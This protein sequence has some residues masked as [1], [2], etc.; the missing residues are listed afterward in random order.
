M[1]D[2][3]FFIEPIADQN[4][5]KWNP[6]VGQ[7]TETFLDSVVPPN[8]RE[9]VLQ[10]ATT[11]IA[12]SIPP[13]RKTG[14]ETGL[15]VGYVQS[16]KTMSFETVIA[17][18][19]DNNF[20]IIIVVAGIANHLLEQSTGRICRDLGLDNLKR[21][22][23]WKQV[24]NPSE[25][26]DTRLFRNV[27]NS[28]KDSSIPMEF[29]ETIL[30]TVL[31]NHKRLEKLIQI[32]RPLD[33]TGVPILL[34]D[35]E[36]DQA[37]LN[38][39]VEQGDEGSTTYL[40]LM[41]LRQELPT[42]TYLQYTAT[43]Q[44]PLLVN[45]IDSLSPNFV[46]VLEPGD[47]YVG[48][49]DFF[50]D[51]S[52]YIKVIPG[53]D[54]STNEWPLTEPPESLLDALRIFMV[55]VTAGIREGNL[56]GSNRSMLIHPSH[57]TRLQ[58]EY[59]NWVRSVVED[60]KSILDLPE[61]ESYRQELIEDFRVAYEDLATTVGDSIPSFS[62]LKS[63]FKVAFAHTRVL[64]V[65]AREGDT[66]KVNW[67]HDY[68]WILVGGQAMD[69]GFTIEGLTI[70]YMPRGIG[71]GNADTIQQ[72]ARFLGYKR[73]YLGFCRV[74]LEAE[75]IDAFR[76]YVEHEEDIRSQL[77]NFQDKNQPLNKWKRAFILNAK[78]R[79][80]RSQVLQFDYMRVNYSNI[81]VAPKVVLGSDSIVKANQQ[82]VNQFVKKLSFNEDSGH[83]DRTKIQ[84]HGVCRKV[85]LQ[86]VMDELLVNIRIPGAVD[87]QRNISLLLNF[88][89]VLRDNPEEVCTI[90]RMSSSEVRVRGIDENGIIRNLYQG[91]APVN[92]PEE[93][94]KIY[95]GDRKIRDIGIVTIQIHE[96]NLKRDD[97]VVVTN[98]PV[99][100]VWVP[101]RLAN[102][103]IVQNQ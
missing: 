59:F 99:I 39:K 62:E 102:D 55:G 17:L 61:N 21:P 42:H 100:A 5:R 56:T 29:K 77:K 6:D 63:Y 75:T 15:I 74:Y 53:E 31:K 82:V 36:A 84:R 92:P 97:E 96:L 32:I 85:P 43:P 57:G 35:D 13:T 76:A 9:N 7:E 103:W 38:T 37:S 79:P 48:G 81:W 67:L 19:R 45:I 95:P 72:R 28:W 83:P 16:G 93:R 78:L 54:I 10:S 60:W 73:A 27:L 65:N 88:D 52:K 24:Q 50:D 44:A 26:D 89:R 66:P 51:N 4:T 41:E 68:G 71:I 18:A 12:K 11:I 94:G 23:R 46:Q 64:E 40:R 47:A 34:I 86:T 69:R 30:I 33:L 22:R 91:E 58:H 1:T 25:E 3:T 80:C 70:T 2:K 49:K 20:Q 8:S 101:D 87:S 98:V 90:F 14:Q